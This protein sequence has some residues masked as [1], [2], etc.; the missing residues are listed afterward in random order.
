MGEGGRVVTSMIRVNHAGISMEM[1]IFCLV[2]VVHFPLFC[3]G[4][5][6]SESQLE[7][8]ISTS[9]GSLWRFFLTSV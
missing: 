5:A 4:I 1:S 6:I 8:L 7:F 9:T 2:C 3:V